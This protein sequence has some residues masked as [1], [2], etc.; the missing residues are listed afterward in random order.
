VATTAGKKTANMVDIPTKKIVKKVIN[1]SAP[2][3]RWLYSREHGQ[4]PT[5]QSCI[6]SQNP[7]HGQLFP[8]NNVSEK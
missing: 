4:F 7:V 5:K 6:P 1:R 3:Q 8:T 2:R